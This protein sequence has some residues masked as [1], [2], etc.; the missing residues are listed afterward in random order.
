MSKMST[1][2][3][4]HK[5]GDLMLQDTLYEVVVTFKRQKMYIQKTNNKKSWSCF[6]GETFW[7]EYTRYLTPTQTKG[8]YHGKKNFTQSR[9][10]HT[11]IH[12]S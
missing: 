10:T 1:K 2:A 4:I 11:V 8:S 5:I 3:V 7:P 6:F 9:K 12:C